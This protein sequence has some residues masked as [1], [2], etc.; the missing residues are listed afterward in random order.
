MVIPSLLG[1]RLYRRI[2][3]AMFRRVV[4]A[5]VGLSGLGLI[6]AAAQQLGH[7]HW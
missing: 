6:A 3:E 1:V 4:L 7:G 2:S 5:L